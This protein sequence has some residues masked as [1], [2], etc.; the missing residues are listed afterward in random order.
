MLKLLQHNANIDTIEYDG[1]LPLHSAT[2]GENV[3]F[4]DYLIN[5][6]SEGD[7]IVNKQN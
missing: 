1:E 5:M 2:I 4:I 6:I 7:T 3:H